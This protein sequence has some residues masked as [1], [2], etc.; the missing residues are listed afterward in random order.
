MCKNML[1]ASW[2]ACVWSL[3]DLFVIE[4]TS[5]DSSS[6]LTLKSS[7]DLFWLTYRLFHH[8]IVLVWGFTREAFFEKLRQF[9]NLMRPVSR[10]LDTWEV[11]SVDAWPGF[12]WLGTS[13]WRT[14]RDQSPDDLAPGHCNRSPDS[15]EG[16]SGTGG[17]YET[18]TIGT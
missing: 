9:M 11:P 1:P 4:R 16:S 18:A 6:E 12:S 2:L 5:V 13:D 17:P 14:S 8:D 7:G 15:F 10:C 3:L